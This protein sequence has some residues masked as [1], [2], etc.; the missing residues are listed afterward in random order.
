M[1]RT[2]IVRWLR[3]VL[4]LAALAIL[5]T[6]FLLARHPD[7]DAAIPYVQGGA[8]DA[9]R[10]PGITGPRFS[11]V[12]P[13]GAVVTFSAAQAGIAPRGGT[14]QRPALDWRGRDG[15]R[16]T[17]TAGTGTQDGARIVLAGGVEMTLSSGWRVTAPQIEADTGADRLTAPAAVSVAAPF[18]TL[19]AGGMVLSRDPAGAAVLELNR[20]VRLLYRPEIPSTASNPRPDLHVQPEPETESR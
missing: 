15:L 3:V 5:S 19:D 6:L 16:A 17:L 9:A 7:P 2:R 11:T 20:G 18:G 4:P 13:D 14:A 8:Q 12:T 10:A 1:G